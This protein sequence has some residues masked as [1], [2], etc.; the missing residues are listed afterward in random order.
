M[1]AGDFN[2]YLYLVDHLD[3]KVNGETLRMNGTL[4]QRNLTDIYRTSHS[5]CRDYAF[6]SAAHGSFSKTTHAETQSKTQ[7]IKKVEIISCVLFEHFAIKLKS[8]NT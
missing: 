7:H 8:E 5:N 4:H 1:I 6:N 2:I 3:K